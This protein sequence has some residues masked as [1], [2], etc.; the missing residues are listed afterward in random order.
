[1]PDSE[2]ETKGVKVILQIIVHTKILLY[3][4]YII[5]IVIIPTIRIYEYYP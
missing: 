1:M 3:Y 2:L 5:I 4:Y